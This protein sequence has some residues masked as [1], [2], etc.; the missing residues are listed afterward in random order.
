MTT[1]NN[2][3]R[4]TNPIH[5]QLLSGLIETRTTSRTHKVG[6]YDAEGKFVVTESKVTGVTLR[7]PLAQ[8]ISEHNVNRIAS[9][10]AR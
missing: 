4:K 8:N 10:W 6:T 3:P 2:M 5:Q 1:P 7:H 9:R